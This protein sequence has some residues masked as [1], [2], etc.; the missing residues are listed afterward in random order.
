M[1]LFLEMRANGTCTLFNFLL[2]YAILTKNG[3]ERGE[4]IM[5]SAERVRNA[6][7]GKLLDRQPIDG[8]VSANL[9]EVGEV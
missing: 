2:I 7:Q 1:V 8:W 9:S 3:L 4:D 5:D 6:I